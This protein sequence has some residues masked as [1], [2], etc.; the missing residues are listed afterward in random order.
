MKTRDGELT[1]SITPCGRVR[2]SLHLPCGCC[3]AD[4]YLAFSEAADLA[5]HLIIEAV[6]AGEV[7]GHPEPW[8]LSEEEGR[9]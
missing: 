6:L 4:K 9:A 1:T 2:I 8:R 3:V 7:H 5:A